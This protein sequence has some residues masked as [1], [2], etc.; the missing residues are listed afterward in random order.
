MI[1]TESNIP[2]RLRPV[3]WTTWSAWVFVSALLP[4]FSTIAATAIGKSVPHDDSVYKRL[5]MSS[6]LAL[7]VF[8]TLAPP[9]MQG[10]VLKRFLPRLSVCVWSLGILV[11]TIIWLAVLFS[12]HQKGASLIHAG[13]Q[14][15]F[16]LQHTAAIERLANSPSFAKIIRLSWAPFLLW[17]IA[18]NTL[19]SLV[20]SAILGTT[21]GIR[22]A[23]LLFIVASVTGAVVSAIVEQLYQITTTQYW[24][25]EWALNGRTWAARIQVLITRSSVGAIWGATT[26]I[27]VV[28][29]SRLLAPT[30][31]LDTQ[32]F[33]LH[34]AGGLTMA[35]IAPPL[36]VLLTLLVSS[37]VRSYA[38]C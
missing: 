33:A 30:P 26:A 10:F 5:L 34:R 4:V 6:L 32:I 25:R 17:T 37:L 12:E 22:R 14:A 20:P 2:A 9:F 23:I 19:T 11:S 18:I 21:S 3:T 28:F 13:L 24:F 15:E 31:A 35:T 38:C 27:P 8:T 29:M 36:I 16:Q 7:T 1:S